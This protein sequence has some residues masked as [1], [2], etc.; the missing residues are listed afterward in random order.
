MQRMTGLIRP[1]LGPVPRTVAIASV[2]NGKPEILD[3]GATIARR[4]IQLPDPFEDMGGMIVRHLAWRVHEEAGD[5][6][7]TAAVIATALMAEAIRVIEAG[8][9]PVDVRRG[10]EEGLVVALA[11]LQR[12][13][14][15]IELPEEIARV[16]QGS[17]GTPKL[18]EMIG[19][20]VDSVGQDGAVLVENAYG[21]ETSYQ[22]IEGVRWDEGWLSPSFL[23]T[24]DTTARL[25]DPRV[26][27]TDMEI[28]KSDQLLPALEVCL[29]AGETSLF[30][31]APSINDATLSML[32]VN[33]ERGTLDSIAVRAPSNGEQRL[34]IL[35]DLAVWTG[36]RCFH[37]DA[38]DSLAKVT[39]ADLGKAR[40]A[41][42]RPYSFG[43]LGGHG[44]REAIRARMGE[45]RT[46]LAGHKD[47]DW[48]KGKIRERI[49]KL[50]GSAAVVTV[51]AATEAA[52]DELKVRIEAAVT[53]ARAA[54][55]EGVVPG[56][57]AALLAC[58]AAVND[59]L[60]DRRDDASIGRRV[61]ARALAAPMIAI[62]ENAGLDG[63]S[64]AAQ[65]RELAPAQTYDVVRKAWVDP[66]DDGLLDSVAVLKIA[67]DTGVSAAATTLTSGALIHR[68]DPELSLAP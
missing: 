53:A 55:R 13:A 62:A 15:P 64:I 42:A 65:G 12:Q 7:A 1:T 2:L 29:A 37:Q 52:R 14:R 22:Y 38:G 39:L 59:G 19:E 43:L 23:G 8:A 24:A 56:G 16:V 25:L 54:V 32:L 17:L 35:D 67:I 31:I 61:L 41:W 68:A 20:I 58:A 40:Q 33:K 11:E 26:L 21:P 18:A 44:R 49:G 10:V 48:V 27:I 50:A 45:A 9:S 6:T 46:E 28:E 66:W 34:H 51:G 47:D 3:D 63:R 36:G 57:G 4:T 60:A 30:V 5:G